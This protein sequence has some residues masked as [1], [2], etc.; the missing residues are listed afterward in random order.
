[1]V[2]LALSFDISAPGRHD[3][4]NL[5]YFANENTAGLSSNSHNMVCVAQSLC[6]RLFLNNSG[7]GGSF[8][9]T[10]VR[11]VDADG[12][13]LT[14]CFD[15]SFLRSQ[16]KAVVSEVR[17]C[18]ARSRHPFITVQMFLAT[19]GLLHLIIPPQIPTKVCR[20]QKNEPVQRMWPPAC[21][22]VHR[23]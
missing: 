12:N 5:A 9:C 7:R 13:V 19:D 2:V 1:M 8:M 16:T 11:M 17:H 14:T 4:D 10:D 15:R 18:T 20:F 21:V 23:A 6:H 22:H 3:V